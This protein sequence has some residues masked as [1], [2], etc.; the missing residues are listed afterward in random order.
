[1]MLAD[2]I[3]NLES[4]DPA[5]VLTPG[6]GSGHSWRGQY[7]E[8]AFTPVE[9]ATVADMLEQAKKMVGATLHGWKGGDFWCNLA[10]PCHVAAEGEYG[11]FTD[12]MD[13]WWAVN[14]DAK[15][16]NARLRAALAAMTEERDEAKLAAKTVADHR[17]L[18]ERRLGDCQAALA[19]AEK[20]AE[21]A[22][23]LWRHEHGVAQ[24]C[25]EKLTAAAAARDE[26]LRRATRAEGRIREVAAL[27]NVPDGGRYLNDWEAKA[28]RFASA[29][30]QVAVPAESKKDGVP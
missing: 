15:K 6:F 28:E 7:D 29:E 24:E 16:E 23:D 18:V 26:A 10:T 12:S 14:V 30:R 3:S 11:G 17:A 4:M 27:M 1:M 2:L 5:A 19:A 25:M 8:V 9:S 21:E 20:E 22:R 13:Y